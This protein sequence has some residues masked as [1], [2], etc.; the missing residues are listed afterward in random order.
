MKQGDPKASCCLYA[1]KPSAYFKVF[2]YF[3]AQEQNQ[4]EPKAI[5]SQVHRSILQ[6]P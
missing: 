3:S 4:E 1:K 6:M 5:N 2:M